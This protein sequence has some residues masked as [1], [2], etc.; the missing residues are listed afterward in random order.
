MHLYI[1][2]LNAMLD[3]AR[4]WPHMI[5]HST[6]HCCDLIGMSQPEQWRPP[7]NS[8]RYQILPPRSSQ[9]ATASV[10]RSCERCVPTNNRSPLSASTTLN[11]L[12]CS[13]YRLPL[14]LM[15]Q[16]RWEDRLRNCSLHALMA[17]I[18]LHSVSSCQQN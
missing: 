18:G 11:W 2:V 15:I 9:P 14:W 10:S 17:T 13:R 12:R 6:K 3:T 4:H 16:P 7:M 8:L 5:Y 1:Q